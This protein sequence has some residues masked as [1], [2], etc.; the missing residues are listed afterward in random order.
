M[1]EYKNL[2]YT[3]DKNNSFFP[4]EDIFSSYLNSEDVEKEKSSNNF[5]FNDFKTNQN[6]SNIFNNIND[7]N[8]INTSSKPIEKNTMFNNL[9]KIPESTKTNNDN[10]KNNIFSSFN[11]Y[12]SSNNNFPSKLFNLVPPQHQQKFEKSDIKTELINNKRERPEKN[13]KGLSKFKVNSKSCTSLSEKDSGF[14]IFKTH[15]VNKKASEFS[16]ADD[17]DEDEDLDEMNDVNDVNNNDPIS[18]KLKKNRMAAK[19]SREKRKVYIQNLE[20]RV[21]Y[22]EVELENQKK[23]NEKQN[24]MD[25]LI[26]MVKTTT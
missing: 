22:L 24:R 15:K 3:N 4:E 8:F 6:E 1:N 18:I 2:F 19:K 5:F 17:D 10:D 21:K 20:E 23:I 14:L 11:N 26:E 13:V 9:F 16:D 7:N 25:D 12:N